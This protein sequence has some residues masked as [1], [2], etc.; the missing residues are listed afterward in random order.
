MQGMGEIIIMIKNNKLHIGKSYRFLLFSYFTMFAFSISISVFGYIYSYWTIRQDINVNYSAILREEKLSYDKEFSRIID[1]TGTIASNIIVKQLARTKEWQV[2]DLYLTVDLISEINA[3]YS[4]YDKIENAGVYFYSN[5]G[6]VTNKQSYGSKISYIFF[7]KYQMEP[8]EFTAK[9]TGLNGYFIITKGEETFLVFYRNVYN[10]GYKKITASSFS[11]FSWNMLEKMVSSVYPSPHRGSFLIRMDNRIIG[12]HDFAIDLSQL[13]YSD[14]TEDNRL[15][16]RKM[17]GMDY[18]LS[19][20][21]SDILAL[22]YVI[23]APKSV[24]FKNLNFLKY[25]IAAE[26]AF[27]LLIGGYLAVYFSRKNYMPV[28]R[29]MSLLKVQRS[30]AA[31]ASFQQ[32]YD[33]LEKSLQALVA[34]QETLYRKL[35]NYDDFVE[36]YTIT[37]MMK[38]W[39]FDSGLMEEYQHRV[40]GKQLFTNYRVILFSYQIMEETMFLKENAAGDLVVDYPLMLFSIENVINEILLKKDFNHKTEGI[41]NKGI[42]VEMGD[43]TACIIQS[44]SDSLLEQL[45]SSIQTCI[46]FLRTA[47]KINAYA[48]V[49]AV[50]TKLGELD[51]AY[52]EALMTITHKSFWGDSLNEVV[53]FDKEK[54]EYSSSGTEHHLMDQARRLSNCLMLREYD[55]ARNILDETIEK[56]FM[57][58]ITKLSYNQYQAAALICIVLSNLNESDDAK[59]VFALYTDWTSSDRFISMKSISDIRDGL[60]TILDKIASKYEEASAGLAEPEWL[61]RVE[62]YVRIHYTDTEINISLIAD[63]FELGF[64]RVGRVFKKYRGIN[65][66]DYIHQLRIQESKCLME[67]GMSVTDSAGRVGY[68]DAKSFIRAFKRYEGITPGQ[69]KEKHNNHE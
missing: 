36:K 33:N 23:Y 45:K 27:S 41:D 34:G 51:T 59:E 24:F 6:I 16:D 29:L 43:M 65:M 48:T 21:T 5:H 19:S 7:K 9:M 20:V 1:R 14:F 62:E 61:K 12:T 28:E 37:S 57:K 26:M 52:E 11:I 35:N 40:K 58:D 15:Y 31:S 3:V 53:L 13:Q 54:T 44:P 8:E 18:I 25:I 2:E 55:R 63:K 47:L 39:N 69:Y 22:R 68:I 4:N 32:I 49:S 60:H 30:E 10:S 67:Q 50:H 46:R 66:I 38:G 17:N 42:V 64:A 56:C